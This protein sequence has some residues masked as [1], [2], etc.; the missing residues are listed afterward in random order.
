MHSQAIMYMKAV[1]EREIL[2]F[3]TKLYILVIFKLKEYMKSSYI[4]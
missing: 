4:C 2:G 1:S 3:E